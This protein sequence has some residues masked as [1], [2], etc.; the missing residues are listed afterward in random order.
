MHRRMNYPGQLMVIAILAAT[1][2]AADDAKPPVQTTLGDSKGQASP[3]KADM[4]LL[5]GKIITVDA[6]ENIC[7]ALAIRDGRI[8][9]VGSDA[10]IRPLAGDKTT[11]IDLQGKTVV[12]GFTEEHVHAADV[13]SALSRTPYA[14]L[15]SIAEVQDWIRG[16]AAKVPPGT[17]IVVPR[18]DITRLAERRLPHRGRVGRGLHDP[19]RGLQRRAEMGPQHPRFP[20]GRHQ[21]RRLPRCPAAE[22]CST[23]TAIRG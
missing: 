19:S 2:A 3:A 5:G 6:K 12:P 10:E 11:V 14:V 15:S 8:M 1:P 9:A 16:Y 4:V 20:G 13:A 7:Q 21:E 22:S 18:N 23:R 17:W